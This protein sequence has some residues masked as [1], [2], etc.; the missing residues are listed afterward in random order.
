VPRARYGERAR[1]A[2]RCARERDRFHQENRARGRSGVVHVL[3]RHYSTAMEICDGARRKDSFTT[4]ARSSRRQKAGYFIIILLRKL[5]A[6][7]V[8]ESFCYI[9][10]TT[11]CIAQWVYQPNVSARSASASGWTMVVAVTPCW[12]YAHEL[13]TRERRCW[14]RRQARQGADRSHSN[15]SQ[16]T[17]AGLA[18]RPRSSPKD[19]QSI[20]GDRRREGRTDR[21]WR[22]GS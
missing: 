21:R 17:D 22:I 4:K 11:D 6:F 10:G 16:A 7:V 19:P 18:F 1:D 3:Y 12:R 15:A 2:R 14:L 20:S 13:R 8:K 9:N 5:R